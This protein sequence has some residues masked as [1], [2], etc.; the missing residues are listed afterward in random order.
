MMKKTH[1]HEA[2][3]MLLMG[4]TLQRLMTPLLHVGEAVRMLLMGCTL[5][6]LMTPLLHVGQI[7]MLNS[8]L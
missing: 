1:Y 8:H 7:A 2:V 6:R 4:C 3:R 5:Q